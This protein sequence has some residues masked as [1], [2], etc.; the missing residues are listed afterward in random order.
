MSQP[1]RNFF[2]AAFALSFVAGAAQAHSEVST[3]SAVS[4][5]PIASVAQAAPGVLAAGAVFAVK[6]VRSSAYATSYTLERVSDGVRIEIEI[7]ARGAGHRAMPAGALVT[8][9]AMRTG[10]VLSAA[11][12]AIAFVPNTLGRAVLRDSHATA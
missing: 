8:A 3:L 7:N 1:H 4:A 11:D 10:V 5:L 6:D 9:Y 2:A 12:G